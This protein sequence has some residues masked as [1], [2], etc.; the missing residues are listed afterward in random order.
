MATGILTK[1][2]QL[3]YRTTDSGEY[4]LLKDLQEVP[5]LGGSAEKVEVTTLEDGSKRYIKGL[6]E[7]GDLAFKFL[8]EPTQFKTLSELQGVVY[9]Q[10]GLPDGVNGAIGTTAT[11]S[12]EASIRID[13]MGTNAPMTYT[14]GI[15][16]NSEIVFA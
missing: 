16:L 11:F 9:W 1:G 15:A 8:H 6:I 5:E 2:I 4:T 3:S 13:S 10:V 12:G 14:L 7:Y